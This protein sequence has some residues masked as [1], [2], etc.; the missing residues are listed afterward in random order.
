MW[1]AYLDMLTQGNLTSIC[2]YGGLNGGLTTK[3][4]E[5]PNKIKGGWLPGVGESPNYCYALPLPRPIRGRPR[6][7]KPPQEPPAVLRPVMPSLRDRA[8]AFMLKHGNATTKQLQAIGVH[9]CYLSPMCEEG[10][11]IR[12]GH[13]IY[14]VGEAGTPVGAE[15][16]ANDA[17]PP[18]KN[19]SR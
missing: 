15:G 16:P 11:L 17:R 4:P 1:T 13:G 5:I 14:G 9:R 7:A 19:P 2:G 18:L 10:L 12:V 8:V 6:A 3:N